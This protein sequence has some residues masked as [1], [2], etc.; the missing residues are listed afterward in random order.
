[1]NV[2]LK[3][4]FLSGL[5]LCIYSLLFYC[6]FTLQLRL[7]FSSF[8]SA[9]LAYKE[10]LDP[11]KCLVA[12]YF[13]SPEKLPANL[14]PPFFLQL[15]SP[16]TELNFQ[17]AS[18]LWFLFSFI[19][20]S[21]GALLSFKITCS[22]DIFKNNWLILLFIYLGMFSTLMNIG[23]GQMGAILFF[24]IIVGYYFYLQN[25]DYLAGGFWGVII[26]LKFFPALLFI[27]VL[28]QKRYTVFI[29]ML[30]TFLLACLLPFLIKGA[31]IYSL[32]LNMLPRVLWF[33]DN[34]NASLYGFLFRIFIDIKSPENVWFIKITYLFFFLSLL[35]WYIKKISLLGKS[36][37]HRAFCFTLVMMLLMS[38]LGWLY[39]FSL[40]IMPLTVIWQSF[41]Q[42]QPASNTKRALWVVGL[43][44]IN[45]PIGY[46]QVLDMH[47]YLYKLTAYSLY[48]YG[49][50]II[51]YLVSQLPEP[52]EVNINK[53][54]K[55]IDLN[56]LKITLA[57][58]LLMTISNLFIKVFLK[59][60]TVDAF[61]Q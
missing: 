14:N 6:Q 4:T 26:A 23:I 10:N 13:A 43:F 8:Y 29:V 11:Y 2:T 5:F 18:S 61:I 27:Y 31:S 42:E 53:Q 34:W 46:V 44:I 25:Q 24:C 39:Y 19:L 22:K 58:G 3:K 45:F 20:G 16:L 7:D 12:S 49:L 30:L 21:L 38:P 32:Y 28:I 40:L 51:A 37:D 56:P 47:S 36:A 15:I 57:L 55:I 48:F 17:M 33:G 59:I 35:I 50:I 41:F 60:K 52:S 54:E 9:A 1:M